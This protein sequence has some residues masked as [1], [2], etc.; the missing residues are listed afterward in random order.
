MP[1]VPEDSQITGDGMVYRLRHWPDLPSVHRTAA[2]YRALSL[3]SNRRVNRRWFLKHSRMKAKQVDK[4]LGTLLAQGALE[5][6]DVSG[7]P[8]HS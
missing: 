7:Y 6:V 4:L 8:A 5:I 1:H 2:V 3:M